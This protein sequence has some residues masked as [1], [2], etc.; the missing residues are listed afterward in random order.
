MASYSWYVRGAAASSLLL[1]AAACST[2]SS[3]TGTH[4][5]CPGA[6]ITVPTNGVTTV[7]AADAPCVPFAADGSTYMIVPQFASGTGPQSQQSYEM[8]TFA[9]AAG[10]ADRTALVT[11]SPRGAQFTLNPKP[12]G[13]RQQFDVT[14]RDKE[15][16][17][18]L[19]SPPPP[20]L[21]PGIA[22]GRVPVSA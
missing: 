10:S 18:G 16:Q 6:T 13:L 17:L 1:G 5:T 15:R 2:G 21:P 4:P 3:S 20:E 7:T 9:T 19:A 11:G 14:L 8:G 22:R 12:R